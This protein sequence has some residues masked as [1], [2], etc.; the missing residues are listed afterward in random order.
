MARHRRIKTAA[1][2]AE[3]TQRRDLSTVADYRAAGSKMEHR[4]GD[5]T[6]HVKIGRDHRR[7][8]GAPMMVISLRR[9]AVIVAAEARSHMTVHCD[10]TAGSIIHRRYRSPESATRSWP[11]GSYSLM[12]SSKPAA[13]PRL[14]DRGIARDRRIN[15]GN[16]RAENPQFQ[17]AQSFT[18]SRERRRLR[19]RQ[20]YLGWRRL[21][22][23]RTGVSPGREADAVAG[24][25]KE[26]EDRGC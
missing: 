10:V 16:E 20:P 24:S 5:D 15:G 13:K 26:G 14:P 4:R 19:P 22:Q 18:D 17:E 23:V 6:V 7:R 1:D 21:E 12:N 11:S 3:G 2:R 9:A 25:H 8:A